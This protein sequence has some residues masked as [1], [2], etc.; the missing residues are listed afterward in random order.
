MK[1]M[2]SFVL[3][4]CS[5]F[6]TV[7]GQ[8]A[9]QSEGIPYYGEQFYRDLSSGV[10]NDELKDKLQHILLAKHKVVQGSYDEVSDNCSGQGCYEHV[11]LG[12]DGARTWM[13][14][15]Y[16]ITK[17]DGQYA[18]PDMYCAKY[19]TASEFSG[20]GAPAPGRYPDGNI[21]NTEHTWPQSR[22]SNEFN[23]N[24]QKSDLHHLYPTDNEMNSTRGNYEFGEVVQDAKKLKCPVSRFGKPA[25]GG[26]DVFEPP[27][28]H[29]GNVA[30]AL[31]YFATNY[32]MHI[33]P[34][35]EA[36]LRKW[37]KE[38]PVDQ[39][40]MNRNVEIFKVQGNRNP[41][42]DHPE[43]VDRINKF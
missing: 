16:Y 9:L 40:E 3:V 35:Q 31:F 26:N 39:E 20:N 12:Y 11:V 7:S 33:S 28:A 22:F 19:R 30:R 4:V 43:L 8:A 37:H 27:T 6:I 32:G 24:M 18:I 17:V 15:T 14:G 23:K 41:F 29:K 38:D 5:L 25:G 34:R 42:I 36:F 13:M 10:S 21:L 2:L 1:A